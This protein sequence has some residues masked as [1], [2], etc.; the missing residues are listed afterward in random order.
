M[1]SPLCYLALQDEVPTDRTW[2]A[3]N[4]RDRL[5]AFVRRKRREEWLLGRW[6]AKQALRRT[7]LPGIDN[8]D[9][10]DLEVRPREDG[11]PEAFLADESLPVSL[12]ISHRAGAGLG[13]TFSGVGVG[14][15][16]EWVEPRSSAFV[17]DYFTAVESRWIT[18]A[19]SRSTA[20]RANG[21]WS[22]KESVLKV[23]GAG[24]RLDT[25]SLEVDASASE[26]VAEEWRSFRVRLSAGARLF[27]GW[28]RLHQGWVLTVAT[29]CRT[30]A[31]VLATK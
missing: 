25:R 10:V 24:L 4:E 19:Q 27:H 31:P 18:S 23:L 11:S 1:E 15:D 22:A 26:P 2:L 28:W 21:L 29:E 14:C 17:G 12:S 3:R 13:V 5:S 8:V 20:L 7:R 30:A 16:L 9:L 6:A